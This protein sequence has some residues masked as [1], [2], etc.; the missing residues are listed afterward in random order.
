MNK[1]LFVFLFLTNQ[2]LMILLGYLIA[3][4]FRN[5]GDEE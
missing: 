3:I 4:E 1:L 2:V 5:K